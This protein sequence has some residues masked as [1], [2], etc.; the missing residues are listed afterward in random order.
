MALMNKRHVAEKLMQLVRQTPSI[1]D[2]RLAEHKDSV[3]LAKVWEL[4]VDKLQ[5]F[6]HPKLILASLRCAFLFFT[7][8]EQ[9]VEFGH[10][11]R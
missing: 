3:L 7:E 11:L 8:V 4:V 2:Q 1:H 10:F 5:D 6:I 9:T